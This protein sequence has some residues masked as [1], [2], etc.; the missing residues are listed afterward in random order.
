MVSM[1]RDFLW[2]AATCIAVALAIGAAISLRGKRSGKRR[3]R[4]IAGATLVHLISL[5]SCNSRNFRELGK[6]EVFPL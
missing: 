2:P 6:F 3:L 5:S 1:R 4:R